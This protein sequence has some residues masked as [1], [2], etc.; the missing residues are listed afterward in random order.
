IASR[1]I[2]GVLATPPETFDPNVATDQLRN[3]LSI[4]PVADQ[5][6]AHF[7]GYV[8]TQSF[9]LRT[10]SIAVELRRP[11]SGA[12]TIFAAA[13]DAANWI[14]F[15]MEGDQLSI[16]SHTKGRVASKKIEY[17]AA[18]HRFLRLRTSTVAPVAVWETSAD[19][20]N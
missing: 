16:E 7:S 1:W 18:Q 19:G 8:S 12:I 3:V 9:D 6:G 14:G 2:V 11:A 10:S 17:S 5:H 13:I 4:T 20:R 15:R